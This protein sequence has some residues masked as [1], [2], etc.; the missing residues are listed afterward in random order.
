MPI[1][2][3]APA[4]PDSYITMDA[5]NGW[6]EEEEKILP[7]TTTTNGAKTIIFKQEKRLINENFVMQKEKQIRLVIVEKEIDSEEDDEENEANDQSMDSEYCEN[8][9]ESADNDSDCE[10]TDKNAYYDMAA[11]RS[12]DYYSMDG[13][14]G[15]NYDIESR[16][17]NYYDMDGQRVTPPNTVN[18]ISPYK[19]EICN[20]DYFRRDAIGLHARIH[21]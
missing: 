16:G 9:K 21:S 3:N 5:S 18:S 7:T 11:G 8:G 4:A 6:I 13:G 17:R 10:A 14:R 20:M 15:Y 12:N 19:C 1:K 2:R